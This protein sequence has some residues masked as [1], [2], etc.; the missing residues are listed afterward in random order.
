MLSMNKSAQPSLSSIF[1][2]IDILR[3]R[4][5]SLLQNQGAQQ[6]I[7]LAQ[8]THDIQH[9]SS[10]ATECFH[11]EVE[12]QS[13]VGR[14]KV[15]ASPVKLH[16]A[17]QAICFETLLNISTIAGPSEEHQRLVEHL[18]EDF[19]MPTNLDPKQVEL[20]GR[21][22]RAGDLSH[23]LFLDKQAPFLLL[24]ASEKGLISVSEFTTLMFRHMGQSDFGVDNVGTVSLFHDGVLDSQALEVLREG[25]NMNSPYSLMTDKKLALFLKEM[26]SSTATEQNFFLIKLPADHKH[27]PGFLRLLNRLPD[28]PQ[29]FIK[30]NERFYAVIPSLTMFQKHLDVVY[31]GDVV[32]AI[33]VLGEITG[34]KIRSDIDENRHVVGINFPQ[35]EELHEADGYISLKLGFAI[36]DLYHVFRL[37]SIPQ[38]KRD[39]FVKLRKFVEVFAANNSDL[40]HLLKSPAYLQLSD[41]DYG[42]SNFKRVLQHRDYSV[43]D[44]EKSIEELLAQES[45]EKPNKKEMDLSFVKFPKINAGFKSKDLQGRFRWNYLQRENSYNWEEREVPLTPGELEQLYTQGFSRELFRTI[46][47]LYGEI[48][49]T[50][51]SVIRPFESSAAGDRFLHAFISNMIHEK[52]AWLSLGI[53]FEELDWEKR[54]RSYA[55]PLS[56][57][58]LKY[59]KRKYDEAKERHLPTSTGALTRKSSA[60]GEV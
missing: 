28:T 21:L 39:A 37:S 16:R 58:F 13:L 24:K 25:M 40:K 60:A 2:D 35:T 31:E 19:K 47:G 9:I 17:V 53:D 3:N 14:V 41:Q 27:C 51:I 50:N 26:R 30:N 43:K 7:Q 42:Q 38:S 1:K 48:S 23:P 57:H 52:E 33:P 11:Q 34:D 45:I 59:F 12:A 20:M 55:S 15:W 32:Q 49:E 29:H 18:P 44:L 6:K 8:F 5:A 4:V 10:R 54:G 36:H 22:V 56:S 46:L